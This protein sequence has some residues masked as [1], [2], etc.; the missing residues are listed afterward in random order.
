MPLV[1]TLLF[2]LSSCFPYMKEQPE[3]VLKRGDG[4][5]HHFAIAIEGL[6]NRGERVNVLIVVGNISN[7]TS[8]Y[9]MNEWKVTMALRLKSE[10]EPYLMDWARRNR[11]LSVVDREM[12]RGILNEYAFQ[13]TGAVGASRAAELQMKGVTHLLVI[14]FARNP[15]G[16]NSI[17]FQQ[18]LRDRTTRRLIEISSG[19][20][21]STETCVNIF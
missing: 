15:Y 13:M 16:F 6:L 19:S 20:V 4:Y 8:D 18:I 2:A 1:L 17:T 21:L 7:A 11:N 10:V 9:G 3:C 14:D 12:T 5:F